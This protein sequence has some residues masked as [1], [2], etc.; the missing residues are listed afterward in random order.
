[1]NYPVFGTKFTFDMEKIKELGY[2][3]D[4]MQE[5]IDKKTDEI[6]LRKISENIYEA[7]ADTFS[8]GKI[9][10]LTMDY[11][12]EQ[13]WF[14]NSVKEWYVLKNQVICG[15]FIADGALRI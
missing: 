7:D 3:Y 6:G 10:T 9:G 1:M 13:K 12:L 5:A 14:C 8:L 2:D 4:K 11:L 15:D